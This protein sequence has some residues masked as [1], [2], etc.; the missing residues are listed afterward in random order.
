ME[1]KMRLV[2]DDEVVKKEILVQGN[3]CEEFKVAVFSDFRTEQLA[4]DF[5]INDV[6]PI[7]LLI[8][9]VKEQIDSQTYIYKFA[10]ARIYGR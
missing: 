5:D 8:Y 10:G 9:Q 7:F 1:L 4:D 3:G 6:A 2:Y